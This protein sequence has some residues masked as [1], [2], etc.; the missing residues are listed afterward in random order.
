MPLNQRDHADIN[1]GVYARENGWELTD[2]RA[3]A[4]YVF[5]NKSGIIPYGT[6][7]LD[8]CLWVESKELMDKLNKAFDVVW[9][10]IV[11]EYL[12]ELSNGSWKPF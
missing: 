7:V 11:Y 1:W 3:H 4:K 10:T 9:N 8:G 2:V 5:A 6:Y 12:Q